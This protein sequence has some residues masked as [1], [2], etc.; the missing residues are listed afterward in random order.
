MPAPGAWGFALGA[1]FGPPLDEG[2]NPPNPP[3]PGFPDGGGGLA[4]GT[5]DP[6]FGHPSFAAAPKGEPMF[7]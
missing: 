1:T 5:R 6:K 4:F 7:C 2:P 3:A